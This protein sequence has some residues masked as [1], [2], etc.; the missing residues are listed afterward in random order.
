VQQP[1]RTD[2]ALRR[3]QRRPTSPQSEPTPH[4]ADFAD[5]QRRQLNPSTLKPQLDF[6]LAHLGKDRPLLQLPGMRSRP[7]LPCNCGAKHEFSL[8]TELTQA[9]HEL[10]QQ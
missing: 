5:W 7:A 3:I 2:G 8:D 9:L 4:Y 1:S 10:T 6:W